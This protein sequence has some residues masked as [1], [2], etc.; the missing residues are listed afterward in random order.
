M[1]NPINSLRALSFG[2]KPDE[3]GGIAGSASVGIGPNAG[4]LAY[5]AR[6]AAERPNM[7]PQEFRKAMEE[8]GFV[9]EFDTGKLKGKNVLG[10]GG[11]GSLYS[12][13]ASLQGQGPAG[14]GISPAPEAP[15]RFLAERPGDLIGADALR[16]NP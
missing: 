5:A 11:A 12:V 16:F 8:K 7:T 9:N 2:G 4:A 3:S 10:A 6:L 14:S 13:Y 1:V 15:G